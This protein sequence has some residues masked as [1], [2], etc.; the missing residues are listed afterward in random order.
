MEYLMLECWQHH[1]KMSHS[2][3]RY[4]RQSGGEEPLRMLCAAQTIDNLFVMVPNMVG[5]AM[6]LL[7]LLV[8]I[9]LPRQ[10]CL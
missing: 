8:C 9:V 2:L 3:R 7:A 10:A 4:Q 5:G 6:S 1:E